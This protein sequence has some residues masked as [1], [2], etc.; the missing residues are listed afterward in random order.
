MIADY[1]RP[2]H[3]SVY[4]KANKS[5]CYVN[6]TLRLGDTSRRY[7]DYFVQIVIMKRRR[8]AC[9]FY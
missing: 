3:R 8:I 5:D 2:E 1:T 9:C 4:K 7:D 6:F